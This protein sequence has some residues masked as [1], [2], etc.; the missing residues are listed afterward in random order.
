MTVN[1]TVRQL[2][3]GAWLDTVTYR[4]RM[5]RELT[6]LLQPNDDRQ[7]EMLLIER[8][9]E[10]VDEYLNGCVQPCLGAENCQRSIQDERDTPERPRLPLEQEAEVPDH[11]ELF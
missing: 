7:L 2:H 9:K 10:R 6:A 1:V 3:Q 11:R 4:G 5:F 8:V